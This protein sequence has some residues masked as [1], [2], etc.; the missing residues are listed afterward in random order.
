[1]WRIATYCQAMEQE[2]AEHTY[3]SLIQAFE[4][5]GGVTAEVLIDNQ[6]SMVVSRR[7]DGGWCSIRIFWSWPH[8]MVSARVHAG[9]IGARTKGKDERMGRA[10]HSQ[11]YIDL[12]LNL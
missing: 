9:R 12:M 8:A 7:G 11:K 1:M 4:Y 3:E 10:I 5:F 2:S 6:K